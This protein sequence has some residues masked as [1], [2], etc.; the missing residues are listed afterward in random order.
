M[1]G[2]PGQAH[3]TFIQPLKL[4]WVEQALCRQHPDID[5]FDTEC[6]LMAAASICYRCP[7]KSECLDYA[8][9]TRAE[10]GIWAGLWGKQLEAMIDHRI[11]SR[12]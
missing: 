11:R 12:S 2:K 9:E 8:V 4:E 6:G 1:P 5:W 3:L 10:D 7:V